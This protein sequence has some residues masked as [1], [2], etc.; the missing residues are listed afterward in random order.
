MYIPVILGILLIVMSMGIHAMAFQSGFTTITPNQNTEIVSTL[1]AS[2]SFSS[3]IGPTS[4]NPLYIYLPGNMWLGPYASG[5]YYAA[6]NVTVTLYNSGSTSGSATVYVSCPSPLGSTSTTVTVGASSSATATLTLAPNIGGTIETGGLIQCQVYT[7]LSTNNVT[8]ISV[9]IPMPVAQYGVDYY[10]NAYHPAFTESFDAPYFVFSGTTYEPTLSITPLGGLSIGS[11]LFLVQTGT[12]GA[13]NSA[14]SL[15]TPSSAGQSESL[16]FI[17]VSEPSSSSSGGYYYAIEPVTLTSVGTSGYYGFTPYMPT[18][19]GFASGANWYTLYLFP[20]NLTLIFNGALEGLV[21][22]V[23]VPYKITTTPVY[24]GY[25]GNV[26]NMP[27]MEMWF[28]SS[29]N[30]YVLAFIENASIFGSALPVPT[31]Y[32]FS[33]NLIPLTGSSIGYNVNGTPGTLPS[34]LTMS[35]NISSSAPLKFTYTLTTPLETY[36]VTGYG[37][38][39]LM[40]VP[41]NNLVGTELSIDTYVNTTYSFGFTNSNTTELILISINSSKTLSSTYDVVNP[42]ITS[43]MIPALFVNGG[44]NGFSYNLTLPIWEKVINYSTV[45]YYVFSQYGGGLYSSFQGTTEDYLYGF[46]TGYSVDHVGWHSIVVFVNETVATY[47]QYPPVFILPS[48]NSAVNT[49]MYTIYP[50]G[51]IVQGSYITVP[52]YEA[53][54]AFNATSVVVNPSGDVL[55]YLAYL[56][57]NEM[58]QVEALYN[59][60]IIPNVQVSVG[61]VTPQVSPVIE[62]STSASGPVFMSFGVAKPVAYSM[63][64]ESTTYT[65][66]FDEYQP[67]SEFQVSYQAVSGPVLADY[68]YPGTAYDPLVEFILL[69]QPTSA[70]SVQ[71]VSVTPSSINATTGSTVNMTVTVTLTQAASSTVSFQGTVSL[72]GTQ[73]ASFVVT[74]PQG[75]SS[76]SVTVSF[77]APSQPGKYQGTVSV[78][79]KTASFTLTVTQSTTPIIAWV[80][81][82]LAIIAIVIGVIAYKKRRRGKAV[83][84]EI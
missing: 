36:T 15:P 23:T 80:A 66:A 78:G 45:T 31:L 34:V 72:N 68:P 44:V 12:S 59:G 29:E 55:E 35:G 73:V 54:R 67:V 62:V 40:Y 74:I 6:L 25:A 37:F 19:P 17:I 61:G 11:T 39:T 48:E 52:I 32:M 60:Q 57:I 79:G 22:N 7:N 43:P 49:T 27:I 5:N 46:I 65:Y 10:S 77:T 82:I 21:T 63:T 64:Y 26:Q 16:E 69:Q 76:A 75:Q 2:Y 50:N 58:P 8:A 1:T 81:F 70:V 47:Q 71:S 53:K 30:F 18:Y 14:F 9:Q 20:G 42:P 28:N 51:T 83:Y 41:A 84:I 4:S 38:I 13:D 33:V 24:D 56:G 3:A